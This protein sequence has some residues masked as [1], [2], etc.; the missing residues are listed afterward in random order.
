MQHLIW[1]SIH[2]VVCK[3]NIIIV[4]IYIVALNYVNVLLA[5]YT[6]SISEFFHIILSGAYAGFL[7]G[8]GGQP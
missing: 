4:V 5:L 1:R 3:F 8:G 6:L 2:L 7:R